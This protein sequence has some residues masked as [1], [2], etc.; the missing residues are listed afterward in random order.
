M[1]PVPARPTTHRGYWKRLA[2]CRSGGTG[3]EP[4]AGRA[5]VVPTVSEAVAISEPATLVAIGLGSN[6]PHAVHG[7][8]RGVLRAA[9]AALR[10]RGVRALRLSPII[11][12]APLGPSRR[13]YANAVLKASWPGS[14]DAL[15]HC[16][17]QVEQEFGRK[18]GRRWGAR[19]IDCDLLAFGSAVI[20]HAGLQVP[21]PG[22]PARDFV[23]QPFDAVWPD[24]RHPVLHLTI[25]QLRAR[26]HKPRPAAGTTVD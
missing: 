18:T 7:R 2:G 12:T 26:L 6:M 1:Q 5:G 23:L 4:R 13:R 25:R 10:R 17:K 16:L 3:R 15:L 8:P 11:R 20:H 22:L 24:W 14:A 21:H 19:V 9:V